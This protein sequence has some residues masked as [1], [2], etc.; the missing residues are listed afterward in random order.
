[1]NTSK[2]LFFPVVSVLAALLFFTA[3]NGDKC[4]TVVCAYD[5]VC[6]NGTCTCKSGYEG[7]NCET[8]TRDKFTGNWSVF[9]KGSTTLASQYVVSIQP[10]GTIPTNV[11]IN[12]F[13]NF[14]TSPVNAYVVGD[15]LYIP[16]QQLQGKVIF[17]VGAISSNTTYGEYGTLTVSYEVIDTATLNVVDF[18][19]YPPD[20]RNPSVWN[21]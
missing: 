13:Y 16:N 19:Y 8:L 12:N 9:E 5:G 11:V 4:K 20:L 17:G 18:G 3:C 21:K 2:K 7:T 15:S 6:N 14:F 1:M 10:T